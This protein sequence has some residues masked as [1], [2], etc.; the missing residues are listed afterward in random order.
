MQEVRNIL[1]ALDSTRTAAPA[2]ARAVALARRFNAELELILCE[3]ERAFALKHQYDRRGVEDARMECIAN[4]RAKLENLWREAGAPDVNVTLD[5]VCESPFYAGIVHKVQESK[6]DLVLKALGGNSRKKSPVMSPSDWE[7]VRTCPVPLMLVGTRTWASPPR[8]CAAVDL[9]TSEGNGLSEDI[10]RTAGQL[11]TCCNGTLEVM[12]GCGE[13]R[14]ES[15]SQSREKL[16]E[17]V[18]QANVDPET[19]HV[20]PGDPAATL[21]E[22]AASRQYDLLVMGALT[23]HETLTAMVG[24]LTGRLMEILDCDFLLL[25]P[26]S[27]VCPV[28]RVPETM[29]AVPPPA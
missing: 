21:P 20:M 1:V 3:A 10:L 27:Y 22:L 7:L 13:A 15:V 25:K 2:V 26:S 5:A 6:P 12:Y 9:G 19:V 14:E 4:A 23:H 24:T 11:S 8:I 29:R 28:Q 18:R 17:R 16:L